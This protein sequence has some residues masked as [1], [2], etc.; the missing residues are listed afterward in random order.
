MIDSRVHCC[1]SKGHYLPPGFGAKCG[2]HL[3]QMFSRIPRTDKGMLIKN[4]SLYRSQGVDAFDERGSRNEAPVVR[5]AYE[6]TKHRQSATV[7][8]KATHSDLELRLRSI[9]ISLVPSCCRGSFRDGREIQCCRGYTVCSQSRVPTSPCS[10]NHSHSTQG[11]RYELLSIWSL[12]M[13]ESHQRTLNSSE[14]H[15]YSSFRLFNSLVKPSG[16]RCTTLIKGALN[17]ES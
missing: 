15:N 4:L 8:V 10:S 11:V 17:G 1:S 2:V 16:S 3:L 13:A 14:I 12:R 6:H 9:S 7:E 5:L